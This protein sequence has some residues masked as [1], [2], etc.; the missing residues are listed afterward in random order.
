MKFIIKSKAFTFKGKKGTCYKE[1]QTKP[2]KEKK[3]EVEEKVTERCKKKEHINCV[4][5]RKLKLRVCVS[6]RDISFNQTLKLLSLVFSKCMYLTKM[7]VKL[8]KKDSVQ[9]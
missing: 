6:P 2:R 3:G 8:F 1:K 7:Y 4:L 5:N 9:H